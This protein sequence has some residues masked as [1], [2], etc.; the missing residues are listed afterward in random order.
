[1]TPN[2]TF[3]GMRHATCQRC[4]QWEFH[5]VSHGIEAEHWTCQGCGET[6]VKNEEAQTSSC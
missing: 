5:S 2:N 3:L 1:M 4:H 6:W